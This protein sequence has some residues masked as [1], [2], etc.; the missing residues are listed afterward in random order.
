MSFWRWGHRGKLLFGDYFRKYL[1]EAKRYFE[2]KG[3][4][5]GMAG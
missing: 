1:G 2:L 3:R 5:S 4:W